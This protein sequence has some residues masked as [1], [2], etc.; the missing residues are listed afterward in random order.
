MDPAVGVL[1]AQVPLPA[2]SPSQLGAVRPR[3]GRSDGE[4]ACEGQLAARGGW[5]TSSL[6]EQIQGSLHGSLNRCNEE[7]YIYILHVRVCGC[8]DLPGVPTTWK[9]ENGPVYI[10]IGPWAMVSLP[11]KDHTHLDSLSL[12]PEGSSDHP[13][14]FA[15]SAMKSTE[16][17]QISREQGWRRIAKGLPSLLKGFDVKSFFMSTDL[18]NVRWRLEVSGHA[19][20]PNG[21]HIPGPCRGAPK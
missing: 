2:G 14:T 9:K 17:C 3:F 19:Y 13:T 11:I 6:Q 12:S 21:G 4:H 10:P 7:V 16:R 8:G 20:H 1:T 5:C 18:P 15:T